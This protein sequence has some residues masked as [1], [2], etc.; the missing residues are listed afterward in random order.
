MIPINTILK[1][2]YLDRHRHTGR[3]TIYPNHPSIGWICGKGW[4]FFEDRGTHSWQS[5]KECS[6]WKQ[7]EKHFSRVLALGAKEAEINQPVRHRGKWRV[8]VWGV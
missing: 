8:K 3:Y 6:T 2:C 7:A 4:G 5:W 1:K